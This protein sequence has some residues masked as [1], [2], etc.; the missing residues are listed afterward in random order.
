VSTIASNASQDRAARPEPP[1]TI[2]IVGTFR[3]LRIEIVHQHAQ[4]GF[5]RPSLAGDGSAARRA[6]VAAQR[7]HRIGVRAATS[8]PSRAEG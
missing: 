1:Y 5:L 7:A 3:H 2:E 8:Q 4:R 6:D